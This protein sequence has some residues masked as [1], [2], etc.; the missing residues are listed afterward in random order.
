MAIEIR[1][2]VIEDYD[3][4]IQLWSV[5]EGI[6]LSAADSRE[7][8]AAYLERNPGCSFTAW[9]DGRLVGAVL[10]GHDGRRG[11]LH[12]LAV[13]IAL[14]GKGIGQALAQRCLDAL[15][16]QGIDKV[17]IFVYNT[18]ANALAFWKHNGWQVRDHLVLMSIDLPPAAA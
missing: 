4:V 8:I 9:E 15:A 16:R 11:Y 2:L 3:Q 6:G 10:S 14:R 18:N 17:H 5:C 12:H 1:A 7:R 13:D